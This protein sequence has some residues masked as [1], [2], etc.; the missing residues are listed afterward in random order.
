MKR[1][2]IFLNKFFC[3][4]EIVIRRRPPLAQNPVSKYKF[5]NSN[6]K[7]YSLW[8]SS[9][10]H[11][12]NGAEEKAGMDSDEKPSRICT[13]PALLKLGMTRWGQRLIF[14]HFPYL[15]QD[16]AYQEAFWNIYLV[17][18]A[19]WHGADLTHHLLKMKISQ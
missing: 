10:L 3:C 9:W 16:P 8:T 4:G 1:K 6:G 5:I 19:L 17:S 12:S 18:K 13:W 2:E 7:V 15:H 14:L 11:Q